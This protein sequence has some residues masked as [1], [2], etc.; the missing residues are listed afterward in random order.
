L[1]ERTNR[2][3]TVVLAP[4]KYLGYI[5]DTVTFVAMGKDA[6][7]QPAQGPKF[8]FES[9][10][11]SKLT[12]DEAGRATL[13]QPG[14][15]IVT[16]R[17]GLAVKTAPVSIR[18]TRRRVQTDAEWRADQDSLVGA[19]GDEKGI[20][21]VVASLG[22]RLAPTAYAQGGGQ[23]ADYGNAAPIGQVGTPPFAAL[24]ETRLGPV[25][26]QTNFELPISLVDLGGRGLATNLMA[27]YN[28][29]TWGA[30]FDGFGGTHYVFDPIQGWPSPGF[31]L[32]FGR[33]VIHSPSGSTYR[34]MFVEANGTRHDLGVGSDTGATLFKRRMAHTSLTWATRL[35]V[36][37]ITKTERR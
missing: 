16:A 37:F 12:I 33:I 3:S 21:G 2:V 34:Y 17:A 35:E 6:L 8:S 30:Y 24:E 22:E 19:A 13:L 28:S 14:T 7:G 26:P 10:D 9:S 25:M 36:R 4:H 11:L 27:Y 32:G 29:N 20:G 15:V 1:V 23:G 18:S 31:S 5:G